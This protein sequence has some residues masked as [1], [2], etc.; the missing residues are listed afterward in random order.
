MNKNFRKVLSF[1]VKARNVKGPI[2]AGEVF[3]LVRTS[4][5][6]DV[7]SIKKIDLIKEAK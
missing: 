2:Y 4:R 6:Y 5:P 1:E 3:N 7:L